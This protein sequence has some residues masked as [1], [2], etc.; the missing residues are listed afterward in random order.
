MASW[1]WIALYVV[2]ALFWL[3][4]ARWGGSHRLA[5]TLTSGLLL[6][7]LAPRWSREG[8]ELFAWLSLIGSSIW[9]VLGLLDPG[10]R[11]L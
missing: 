10:L 11:F 2:Q 3:W 7:V 8:L 5:G 4:I 1:A 6:H 9:F